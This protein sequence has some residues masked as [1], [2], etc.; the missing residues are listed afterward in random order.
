MSLVVECFE[1][2]IEEDIGLFCY[3]E[4][5]Q[6][7][8]SD[9]E[10]C[11]AKFTG[12]GEDGLRLGDAAFPSDRHHPLERG[13]GEGVW[14]LR[15]HQAFAG[16][17]GV[18]G[19]AVG[20]DKVG[21]IALQGGDGISV[22]EADGYVSADDVLRDEWSHGI[23]YKYNG[24]GVGN[25]FREICDAVACRGK[26]ALA[27]HDDSFQFVDASEFCVPR[28]E[29]FPFGHADEIDFVDE[30][31]LLEGSQSME[32]DCLAVYLHELLGHEGLHAL[33]YSTC[34]DEGNVVALLHVRMV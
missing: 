1:G 26:G 9:V 4:V 21:F 18:G 8:L 12:E 29:G 27:C 33:P 14:C 17:V 10:R 2:A 31:M 22:G 16:H 3:F 23:V 15:T 30:R 11:D 6:F 34:K 32:Q 5:A 19:I 7:A 20:R 25:V 24:F 13:K 28:D